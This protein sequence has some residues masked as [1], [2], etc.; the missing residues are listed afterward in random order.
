MNK[1]YKKKRKNSKMNKYTYKSTKNT[2]Q[3]LNRSIHFCVFRVEA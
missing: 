3:M 1:N 2:D